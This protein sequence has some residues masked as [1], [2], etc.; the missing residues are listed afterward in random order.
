MA[1]RQ[2]RRWRTLIYRELQEHRNSSFWLPFIVSLIVP[3]LL[4]G[5][6]L[7]ADRLVESGNSVFD[8]II[9]GGNG[10][11]VNI[12]IRLDNDAEQTADYRVVK[13]DDNADDDSWDFSRQWTFQP[14]LAEGDKPDKEQSNSSVHSGVIDFL[15]IIMGALLF[16]VTVN[17]LLESLFSDRR[18]RSILFWKSMPVSEWENVLCK[19]VIA[20]FVLPVIYLVAV[21]VGQLIYLLLALIYTGWEGQE[22]AA[23]VLAQVEPGVL[24]WRQLAALFNG[25]LWVAP[26]YGWLLLASAA[27][28]RSPFMLAVCPVLLLLL[29][30]ALFFNN[31]TIGVY[32]DE[33]IQLQLNPSVA[34]LAPLGQEI[35]VGEL[36]SLLLGLLLSVVFVI[37]AVWLR[38]HRWEL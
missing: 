29:V 26:I 7:M 36:L 12:S 32:L 31:S 6:M 24:L 28:R 22:S 38:R 8:L 20:L 14:A 16:L 34:R 30:D 18:D 25:A 4:G 19:V 10:H 13:L 27:A 17:Y 21:F 11:L 5:G 33:H 37:L 2:S 9:G 15:A 1:D 35:F 23:Q 3:L